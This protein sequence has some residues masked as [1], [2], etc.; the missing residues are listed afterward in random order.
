MRAELTVLWCMA[1]QRRMP[2][3]VHQRQPAG[4]RPALPV[5]ERLPGMPAAA[6]GAPLQRLQ[7]G[8]LRADLSLLQTLPHLQ[9]PL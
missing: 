2:A 3:A 8:D 1:G 9:V 4:V 5:L 7:A 6:A